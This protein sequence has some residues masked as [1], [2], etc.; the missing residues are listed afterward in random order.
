MNRPTIRWH[1]HN[2]RHILIDHAER[3]ITRREIEEVLL[4]PATVRW[5][6]RNGR[7]RMVGRT[8]GGRHLVV[9]VV[10]V[11]DMC[12]VTAWAISAKRQ[13]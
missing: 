10:G 8:A 1:E 7:W 12:P 11:T 2:L 9:I 6:A 3:K 5:P 13:K 4:D